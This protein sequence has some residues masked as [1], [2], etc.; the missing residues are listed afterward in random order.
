MKVVVGLGNPGKRYVGTRHNVG[1]EVLDALAQ[2]E[3][4]KWR[5][6]F[7]A[8][9]LEHAIDGVRL[10]LLKPQTYMNL[11]GRCVRGVVDYYRLPLTDLLVVCDDINLPLGR[12]RIRPRGSSGGHKGLRDIESHLR[13]TEYARL[14]VGV[15]SPGDRDA[16]DFVLDR[17]SPEEVP[18]VR[19]AVQRA[20]DAVSTWARDGIEP[21]MNRFNAPE[22]S[23]QDT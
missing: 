7:D 12:L 9:T 13:T 10:L 8:L 21:C 14:R 1:F 15:G 4:R 19:R 6:G 11:S 2:T 22:Q 3:P 18:V 20:V 16:V 5:T 23:N 17:F